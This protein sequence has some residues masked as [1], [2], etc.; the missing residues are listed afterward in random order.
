LNESLIG[1]GKIMNANAIARAGF[2]AFT[3]LCSPLAAQNLILNGGFESPAIASNSRQATVPTS[4]TGGPFTVIVNG[5]GSVAELPFPQEG[6]QYVGV[7]T[8]ETLSQQ[9]TAMIAGEY[10]LKWFD[11]AAREPGVISV[12][13]TVDVLSDTSQVIASADHNAVHPQDW[14]KRSLLMNLAP[15]GYTLRFRATGAGGPGGVS[16]L[17]DDVSLAVPEP[18]TGSILSAI[19]LVVFARRQNRKRPL[20]R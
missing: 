19:G 16:P 8:S 17:F 1:K 7:A 3:L 15:G 14:V 10:Q 13:Y 5:N 2:L 20:V 11:S 9:F 4:W 18:C 12:P 6:Q